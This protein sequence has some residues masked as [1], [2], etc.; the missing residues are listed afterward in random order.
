MSRIVTTLVIFGSLL[1]MGYLTFFQ[2]E[3]T[4]ADHKFDSTFIPSPGKANLPIQI[5]IDFSEIP[6]SPDSPTHLRGLFKVVDS[7][8]P[9]KFE[10]ELPPGV[11]IQ[12]G[13]ISGEFNIAAQ[14]FYES[15]ITVFGLSKSEQMRV[16]L[17]VQTSRMG[18]PL[19]R[20]AG[21]VTQPDQT[22]ENYGPEIKKASDQLRSKAEPSE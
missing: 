9:V 14:P 6:E 1:G 7:D 10:W 4:V 17:K 13:Q 20:V 3:K 5:K 15:R 21:F 19:F 11:Q 18:K 2:K 8:G 16:R 22:W 12:S